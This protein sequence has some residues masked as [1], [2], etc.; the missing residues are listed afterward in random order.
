MLPVES[1]F[2]KKNLM[3]NIK[4]LKINKCEVIGSNINNE[5]I[6]E[7]SVCGDTEY[8]LKLSMTAH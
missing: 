6:Q 8:K 3:G 4:G 7:L 1:I 2:E 5:N